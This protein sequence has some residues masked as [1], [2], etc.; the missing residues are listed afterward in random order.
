MR[1]RLVFPLVFACSLLWTV[2]LHAQT[3]T[4]RDYYEDGVAALRSNDLQAARSALQ[5]SLELDPNRPAALYNLGLVEFRAGNEG[6]GI[7]IWRKALTNS[8]GFAPALSALDWAE[9]KIPRSLNRSGGAWESIRAAVIS[10][11]EIL[12]ALTLNLLITFF[13]GFLFLRYFGA[14]RRALLDERPLPP[15]PV[16]AAVLSVLLVFSLVLSALKA[17][18]LTVV[19]ATVVTDR[20]PARTTPDPAATSLF[21]LFEGAEVVVRQSQGDWW[22]VTLPG[23]LTGWVQKDALYFSSSRW[24]AR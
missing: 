12:D 4:A 6:L 18:D 22:Q 11:I 14:R 21:D 24:T 5:Q 20:T 8:P 9:T 17:Y 19:R 13:A 16:V 2:A 15:Y 23:G 3:K 1:F 10:P 7:G